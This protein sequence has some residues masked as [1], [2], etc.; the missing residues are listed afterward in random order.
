MNHLRL[1]ARDVAPVARV[2]M[3]SALVYKGKIITLGVAQY[4]S[5]PL[6]AKYSRNPDSIFL[7]AE[8]DAIR[9]LKDKDFLSSCDLYVC[10]LKYKGRKLV[11]GLACPCEGCQQAIEDFNIKRVFYTKED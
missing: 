9:K 10:R 8:I 1:I 4:K 2:C 7:H 11:D 3:S 5:H 6:Q